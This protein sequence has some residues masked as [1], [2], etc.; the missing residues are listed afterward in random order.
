MK[1]NIKPVPKPRMTKQDTWKKRPVV[2][3]Y[4]KYKD[5]LRRSGIKVK[6]HSQ[7]IVFG[8][9]MPKSY[10]QK[11][12]DQLDNKPHQNR[13]DIDNFVKALYDC[14]MA[15]D[16]DVWHSHAIKLWTSSQGYIKVIDA[17]EI[18]DII[19]T[20]INEKE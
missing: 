9:P 5:E 18:T 6:N 17:P 2:E 4:W 16:K 12:R 10:S 19:L 13:G 15:E 3:K 14:L 11:K 8:V 20:L 1:I 7:L